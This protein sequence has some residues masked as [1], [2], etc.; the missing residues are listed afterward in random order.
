[1]RLPVLTGVM[2]TTISWVNP[3]QRLLW[4][5]SIRPEDFSDAT[6]VQPICSAVS[7]ARPNAAS[8]ASPTVSGTISG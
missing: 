7:S 8:G 4:L 3:I 5:A 6:I 1:M 2:R